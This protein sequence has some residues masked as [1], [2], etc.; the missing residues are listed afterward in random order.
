M[1]QK[2]IETAEKIGVSDIGFTKAEVYADLREI[3]LQ[4][5]TV[6]ADDILERRINPFLILPDAKSVIVLLCSY[7]TGARG[8]ISAY[9]HGRDYHQVMAEKCRDLCAVLEK[10]GYTARG[11]CDTGDLC[12]RYLAWRAGL[13]FVGRN[14]FLISPQFGTYVFIAHIIT[15]CPLPADKPIKRQCAGCGACI[16]ACPGGALE[17]DGNFCP[18]KCLSY[19][20]QKKGALTSAE[21]GLIQKNGFAWGCDVCQAVCPHNRQIP[22]AVLSDFTHNLITDL[23]LDEGISNREFKLRYGNRAFSWRGKNVLLRN[24]AILR[25]K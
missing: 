15:D 11:F 9:A 4:R 23:T 24:L 19:I 21:E 14:G 18:E 2:L 3:L 25:Q 7:Y 5:K 6:F 17:Q 1:K 22:K 16:A 12:E 20:T 13:G 10:E 8:N